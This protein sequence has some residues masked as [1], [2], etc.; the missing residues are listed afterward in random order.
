MLGLGEAGR[1]L[2]GKRKVDSGCSKKLP[3]KKNREKNLSVAG[4]LRS[5]LS[6]RVG[7]EMTVVKGLYLKTGNH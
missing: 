4:V 2:S 7:N 5:R 6:S 1:S 3:S